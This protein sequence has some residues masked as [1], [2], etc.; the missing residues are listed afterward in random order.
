MPRF[1]VKKN[2]LLLSI[3]FIFV[4]Y[5]YEMKEIVIN[6]HFQS[7]DSVIVSECGVVLTGAPGRIREAFELMAQK[8]IKK[9]VI[10][11]VYKEAQLNEIF[12]PLPFY[13][14][15]NPSDVILEK[16]SESTFGNAIQ[17]LAVVKSLHCKNIL[18]ITSQLHMHRASKI[19]RRIFP[20]Q[21]EIRTY[22]V[23]HNSK[24][25]ELFDLLFESTKS[26]FYTVF[27][28]VL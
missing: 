12:P 8:K 1:K 10:S 7:L 14:E 25:N 23:F 3:G 21:I 24:E 11:G 5:I 9:L 22:S 4:L 16:K 15:I 19:F 18:L 2:I 27:G 6:D 17:S 28:R 13:P 20:S 26:V